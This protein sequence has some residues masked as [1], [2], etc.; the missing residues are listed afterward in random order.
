L[1]QPTQ[2]RVIDLLRGWAAKAKSRFQLAFKVGLRFLF[3]T[4]NITSLEA[5][6]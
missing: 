2:R 6:T 3:T 1:P 5:S 4:P